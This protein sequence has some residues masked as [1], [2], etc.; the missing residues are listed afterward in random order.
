[1]SV[2]ASGGGH[3]RALTGVS[4]IHTRGKIC[5]KA[6]G[7]H[8]LKCQILGTQ[9]T[10]CV[11]QFNAVRHQSAKIKKRE[12][13]S[14]KKETHARLPAQWPAYSVAKF[15]TVASKDRRERGAVPGQEYGK[16]R[17]EGL[18]NATDGKASKKQR[19]PSRFKQGCFGG[20][21]Q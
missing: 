8:K 13:N 10:Q 19:C 3:V 7:R 17:G 2:Y 6:M 4:R 11:L 15:S 12:K 14:M 1:M 16:D 9:I 18:E 20:P 5:V 21:S